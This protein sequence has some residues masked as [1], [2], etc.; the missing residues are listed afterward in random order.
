[1]AG[2]H[3]QGFV[4]DHVTYRYYADSEDHA[5]YL[6]GVLN[7]SVVNDSIKPWQS[8]DQ[9]G[10]RDIH[11]RPFE[12]CAIPTFDPKNELHNKIVDVAREARLEM[13]K[14]KSKIGAMPQRHGRLHE[15][16]LTLK[17]F[18]LMGWLVSF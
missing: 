17:S 1:V 14:W 7:S 11:R 16:S 9:Q 8:E 10:E 5:I 18:S 15:R 3:I 13:L 12:V 4:A 2:L 6:V